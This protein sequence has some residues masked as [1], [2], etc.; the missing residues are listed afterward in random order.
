T[1]FRS[2]RLMD[3]GFHAPTLSFPVADTLMVEPTESESLA[4][5]DRFIEAM[6]AIKKEC[7]QIKDGKVDKAHNL[8]K[9]APHTVDELSADE[10]NHPYSRKDAAYPLEWIRD[11]KF[12]PNVARVDNGYGDRNL[13]CSCEGWLED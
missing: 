8:I 11:N 12:W 2:K 4:E 7:D 1:L 13:M 10:W 5:L 6:I 9:N 3:Y